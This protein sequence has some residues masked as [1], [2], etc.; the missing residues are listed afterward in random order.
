MARM[1][2][3]STARGLSTLSFPAIPHIDGLKSPPQNEEVFL[4]NWKT[5]LDRRAA[6]FTNS[7]VLSPLIAAPG[8]RIKEVRTLCQEGDWPPGQALSGRSFRARTP[9]RRPPRSLLPG[10][11][12][13]RLRSIHPVKG[14]S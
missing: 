9:G 14:T 12:V 11:L 2:Q 5:L 6:R 4:Q 7:R 1:S 13:V 10:P 3:G 8:D